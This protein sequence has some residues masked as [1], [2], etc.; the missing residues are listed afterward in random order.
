MPLGRPPPTV[1][2]A[3]HQ[4]DDGAWVSVDD[5]RE[6]NVGDLWRLAG[7]DVCGCRVADFLA[8]AFVGVGVDGDA[9]EARVAG[10]CVQCGAGGVTDWLTLGRVDPRTGTFRPVDRGSVHVPGRSTRRTDAP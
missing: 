10:Q 3:V 8:E 5:A 9:V 2:T 6:V 1:P 7:H 4:L